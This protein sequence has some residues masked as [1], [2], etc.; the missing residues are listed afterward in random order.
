MTCFNRYNQNGGF[1]KGLEL[2]CC[3]SPN[4]S[5]MDHLVS[6]LHCPLLSFVTKILQNTLYI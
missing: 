2:V 6:K 4:Q 1:R 5:R 3:K